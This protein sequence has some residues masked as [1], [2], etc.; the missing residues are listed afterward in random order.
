MER[1]L[2]S[3]NHKTFE[4]IT[5]HRRLANAEM[6]RAVIEYHGGI[7]DHLRRYGGRREDITTTRI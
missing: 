2:N 5:D 4:R 1:H 3:K 7:D 6:E